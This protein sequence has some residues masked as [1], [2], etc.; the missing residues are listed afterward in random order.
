MVHCSVALLTKTSAAR[1]DETLI[2]AHNLSL[3]IRARATFS[4]PLPG[5]N[6]RPKRLV[7]AAHQL[8][9]LRFRL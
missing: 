6:P 4:L 8:L 1:S 5:Q 3:I 2:A 9:R 7:R